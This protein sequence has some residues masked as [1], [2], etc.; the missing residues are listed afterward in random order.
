MTNRHWVLTTIALSIVSAGAQD[1]HFSFDTEATIAALT[2]PPTHVTVTWEGGALRIEHTG[3]EP[4]SVSLVQVPLTGVRRPY[5]YSARM[6]AETLTAPAYLEMWSVFPGA[7]YFSR[8]LDYAF[9][10]PMDWRRCQTPF[11]L[12]PDDPKPQMAI[13]GVRLDGP[14]VVWLDDLALQPM[15]PATGGWTS[16]WRLA[17]ALFGVAAGVWGAAVGVLVPRG[18]A[19]GLLLGTGTALLAVSA[20]AL[21]YG[22]SLLLSATFASA[23]PA[24]CLGVVGL[25]VFGG[26]IP[27]VNRRYREAELRHMHA[28]DVS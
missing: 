3:A 1:A 5:L 2:P 4:V 19:R 7:Q 25:I 8:A 18:K 26:L 13:L 12:K 10:E 20:V 24:L 17:S 27:V 21:A 28:M 11:L 6:K 15:V 23:Y 16:F 22:V 9:T 14:G